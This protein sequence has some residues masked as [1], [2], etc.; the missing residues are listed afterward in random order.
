[1][2]EDVMTKTYLGETIMAQADTPYAAYTASDWAMHFVER[3]GQTDGGHHKAWV[4]DQ[5]ARILKGTPVQIRLAKWSDGEQ[6][7]RI[8]TV[9]PPSEVYL[10]WVELMLGEE[11][12]T[13]GR[14]YSYDEGCAP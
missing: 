9:E 6:D 8:C 12:P 7:Y 2:R 3:Y 14:E 4:L 10:A 13:F 5:V 11:H 1:M